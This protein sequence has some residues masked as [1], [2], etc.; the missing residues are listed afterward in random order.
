MNVLLF[1]DSFNDPGQFH[2]LRKNLGLDDL[3]VPLQSADGKR[4]EIIHIRAINGCASNGA[5]QADFV[6]ERLHMTAVAAFGLERLPEGTGHLLNFALSGA[7]HY[8]NSSIFFAEDK[9]A[10]S[11]DIA[12]QI[13]KAKELG[14]QMSERDI[15]VIQTAYNDIFL[16]NL[17]AQG[18]MGNL[19]E[20]TTADELE[21][22][23]VTA[24]IANITSLYK[25]GCKR[26]LMPIFTSLEALQTPNWKKTDAVFPGTLAAMDIRLAR[27]QL[28]LK[29]AVA[30]QKWDG[31]VVDLID[32]NSWWRE[33]QA[34]MDVSTTLTDAGWTLESQLPNTNKLFFYDDTHPTQEAHKKLAKR[35]VRHI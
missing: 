7:A 24:A 26:L 14:C 20:P 23:Y 33:V 17:I 8:N 31:L 30:A 3:N 25:M 19:P 28:S 21:K 9:P 22:R 18:V 11:F 4:Q 13:E 10:P 27:M 29:E 35:L 5:V 6:A 12:Y 34:K 2:L 15:C 1:G 32:A 16:I